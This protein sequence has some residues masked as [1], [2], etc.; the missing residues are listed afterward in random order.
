MDINNIFEQLNFK[1]K[2]EDNYR[3]SYLFRNAKSF[4]NHCHPSFWNGVMIIR[5]K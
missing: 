1:I 3:K 4:N 2:S 5:E